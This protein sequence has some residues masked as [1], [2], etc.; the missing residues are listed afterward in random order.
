MGKRQIGL[1]HEQGP[2]PVKAMM[3]KP[4]SKISAEEDRELLSRVAELSTFEYE[5]TD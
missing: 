4:L 5:Q 3:Q 1:W 2:E